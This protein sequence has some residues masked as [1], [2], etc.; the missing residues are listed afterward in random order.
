MTFK[1]WLFKEQGT[2]RTSTGLNSG[3]MAQH[4]S[5]YRMSVKPHMPNIKTKIKPVHHSI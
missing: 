1:E 5:R 4:G 2:K 3:G